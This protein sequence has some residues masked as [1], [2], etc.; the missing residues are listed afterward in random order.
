MCEIKTFLH[1]HPIYDVCC[2]K[3]NE[4]AVSITKIEEEIDRAAVALSCSRR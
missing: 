2:S 1:E 4:V 3:F